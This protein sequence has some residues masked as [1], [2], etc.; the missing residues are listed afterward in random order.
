MYDWRKRI[1]EN[2]PDDPKIISEFIS[3]YHNHRVIVNSWEQV[4]LPYCKNK[5]VLDVGAVCHNKHS[6]V[7]HSWKHR[8]IRDASEYVLAVDILKDMIEWIN[9][10]GGNFVYTDATSEVDLKDRFDVVVMGD[11]IEHVDNVAGLLEFGKRHLN[12]DGVMLITTPNPC[13]FELL[14]R[15]VFEEVPI[16]NM[17]HTCWITPTNMN[18]LCFRTGLKLNKIYEI[19]P[20][21]YQYSTWLM[22][23]L[24][25]VFKVQSY[26]YLCKL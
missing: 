6:V 11:L 15:E 13:F 17:E 7:M 3:W 10:R 19:I 24:P 21:N 22:T 5:R 2:D 14:N 20:S 12:K 8:K 4:T 18:E 26:I 23:K 9:E 25:H 16:A 1:E